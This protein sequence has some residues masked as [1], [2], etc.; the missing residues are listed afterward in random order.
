MVMSSIHDH[1]HGKLMKLQCVQENNTVMKESLLV[2]ASWWQLFE[3]VNIFSSLC[4]KH[5]FA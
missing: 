4:A 2:S 5:L 1:K 3:Q